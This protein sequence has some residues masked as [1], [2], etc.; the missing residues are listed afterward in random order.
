MQSLGLTFRANSARSE[1]GHFMRGRVL[2]MAV[3]EC[4]AGVRVLSKRRGITRPSEHKSPLVG[5]SRAIG[6]QVPVA[7]FTRR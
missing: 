4:K 1:V 7:E 3:G 2:S 5:A 6:Q